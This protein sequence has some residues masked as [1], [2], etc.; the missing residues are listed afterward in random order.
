MDIQN[1]PPIP[2][3]I[4]KYLDSVYPEQSPTHNEPVKVLRY[5]GGQRSVVRH[6]WA[7]HEEQNE[8]RLSPE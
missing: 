4:L 8:N 7:V 2:L 5:R 6:L 1:I 3:E